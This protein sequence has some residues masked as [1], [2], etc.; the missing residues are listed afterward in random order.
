MVITKD[1]GDIK[2][3]KGACKQGGHVVSHVLCTGFDVVGYLEWGQ[4]VSHIVNSCR[5]ESLRDDTVGL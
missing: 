3:L 4:E 1:R 5:K 2:S